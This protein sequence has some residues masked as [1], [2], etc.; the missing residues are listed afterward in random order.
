VAD[1]A[2]RASPSRRARFAASGLIAP[3]VFVLIAAALLAAVWLIF[4][5]V[6]SERKARAAAARTDEIVGVLNQVKEAA[7][8]AETGQRGYFITL[9]EKYLEPYRAGVAEY[10]AAYARLRRVSENAPP[11]QRELVDRIGEFGALK[12][13][14]LR[15]SVAQVRDGRVIDAQVGI[16][17]DEGKG[18][19]DRLRG[20]IAELGSLERA[21]LARASRE[22]ESLEARLVPLL[23][24]LLAVIVVALALGL[25][26]TMRT[27]RAE[28]AAAQAEALEQARDRADLLARELNHRVKNLFAVILA[29]VRMS[30]RDEP[31]AKPVIEKIAQRIHA[32]VS[33]HAATQGAADKTEADL[34]ELVDVAVAPYR[35]RSERCTI[36]GPAVALSVKAA[37]PLGLV[38]HE[39]VTNA[40]KYGAWAQAGGTVRI[41][42]RVA[43]GRVALTWRE[44]GAQI[45][46]ATGEGFGT[47][48]IK[49][50]A[51]QLGGTIEREFHPDGIEVRIDFP[52]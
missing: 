4:S 25:W 13:A 23:E 6:Q 47:V 48:L 38:L 10:R 42:W 15:R 7:L 52:S 24:M 21:D 43:E 11:P 44:Q 9:D 49:S 14:E 39:L 1:D 46:S 50:S 29:L 28:A 45:A 40:V 33:A 8:N 5:T 51:Q 26:L 3:A 2:T 16:L 12:F 31:A 19:M 35:S 36:E 17:S 30:G 32:L 37:M 27:V 18:S 41:T 34:R 22:T 20:A